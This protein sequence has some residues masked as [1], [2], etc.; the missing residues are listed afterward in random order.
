VQNKEIEEL[1]QAF[2]DR[3]DLNQRLGFSYAYRQV[4]EDL[5]SKNLTPDCYEKKLE[6]AI[7]HGIESL[8]TN[9]VEILNEKYFEELE[10]EENI[11]IIDIKM[12]IGAPIDRK[13]A[14]L[15]KLE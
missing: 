3:S 8:E 9:R 13:E 10:D 11:K 6:S 1:G 12:T 2:L 4:L 14:E 5:R 15:L 7:T